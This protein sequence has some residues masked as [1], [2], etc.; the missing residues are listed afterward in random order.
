MIFVGPVLP[1]FWQLIIPL[2]I[3]T[4]LWANRGIWKDGLG[5]VE[6]FLDAITAPF[7]PLYKLI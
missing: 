6:T 5:D 4:I 2:W 3:S 7:I 1:A